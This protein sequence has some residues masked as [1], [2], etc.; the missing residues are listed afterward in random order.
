MQLQSGRAEPFQH[1]CIESADENPQNMRQLGSTG[2]YC[3]IVQFVVLCPALVDIFIIKNYSNM[4]SRVPRC[5]C[6]TYTVPRSLGNRQDISC[7]YS[8]GLSWNCHQQHAIRQPPTSFPSSH[9]VCPANVS[10]HHLPGPL[11]LL[12]LPKPGVCN[13]RLVDEN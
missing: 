5:S 12:C 2:F 9:E 4:C 3:N 1:S 10:P 8:L 7:S 11:S 13:L 6:C